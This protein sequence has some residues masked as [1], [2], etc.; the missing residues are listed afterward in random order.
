MSGERG[1]EACFVDTNILVYAVEG[2]DPVRSPRASELILRLTLEDSLRTSTQVIQELYVTLTRKGRSIISAEA[3]LRYIDRLAAWPV[4]VTDFQS[5]R[6]AI[7]LSVNSKLS[8][9]DALIVVAA[10]LSGAK[11]LYTEDLQHGQVLLGVR[12]VN[13]FR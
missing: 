10:G 4:L 13:P 5:V 3:A 11:I 9:W 1:G 6:R 12:I 2:N 8:F 7:D